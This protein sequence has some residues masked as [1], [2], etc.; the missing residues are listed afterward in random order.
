MKWLLEDSNI[1][2]LQQD[3][4]KKRKRDFFSLSNVFTSELQKQ[5]NQIKNFR[6]YILSIDPV[7]SIE[8]FTKKQ[9][10]FIMTIHTS[11]SD[12]LFK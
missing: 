1:Y 5:S 3:K 4:E 2:K 6:S 10:L 8:N 12:K 11:G 7:N 9:C